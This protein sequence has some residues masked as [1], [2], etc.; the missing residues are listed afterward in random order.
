MKKSVSLFVGIMMFLS[1]GLA[2]AATRFTQAEFTTAESLDPV[3]V[4]TGINFTFGD[5]NWNFYPD[6]RYGLGSMMEVGG[7]FGVSSDTSTSND[8]LGVLV[9][10]DFKYQIIKE[11]EGI[12]VD[13]A[14]DLGLDNVIIHDSNATVTTFSTIVSKG[15][16]LTDRGYKLTPYGGLEMAA[17][18]G[19]YDG[20]NDHTSVYVFGG[21]E[22]KLTQKFMVLMELKTGSNMM[23]GV[24]IK[25]EY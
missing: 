15:F 9:G 1:A 3:M 16:S 14:V 19:S 25:F 22:W 8:Q 7:K 6:V 2:G 13:L 17:L 4:Q 23:G 5:H 21:L 20:I 24:G 10:A 18:R 11:T 12:P